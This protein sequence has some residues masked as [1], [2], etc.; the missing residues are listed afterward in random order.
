MSATAPIQPFG[1]TAEELLELPDD[2]MRHELVEGELRTMAPAGE[3]H[4]WV[5][6]TVG[7][8]IFGHVERHDLG[9]VYAAET[10]FVLRR[11][12]DTVRAP[13]VAF[14]AADRVPGKARGF[15]EL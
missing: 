6:M 8:R 7:A 12:P 10:G 1:M 14:V 2:D 4:G 15:A 11:A 5:A 3:G 13:D 9:R